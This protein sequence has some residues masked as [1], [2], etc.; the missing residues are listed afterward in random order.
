MKI[1]DKKNL[2]N[3]ENENIFDSIIIEEYPPTGKVYGGNYINEEFIK[4]II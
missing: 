2:I 1:N 3:E 4:R